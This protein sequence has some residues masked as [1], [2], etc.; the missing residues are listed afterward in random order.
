MFGTQNVLKVKK[1]PMS[2]MFPI[3]KN[4]E[5]KNLIRGGDLIVKACT[6]YMYPYK[7]TQYPYMVF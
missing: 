6:H 2:K 1:F 3:Q 7:Y 4:F 5:L